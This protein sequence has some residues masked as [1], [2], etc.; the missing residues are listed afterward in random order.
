MELKYK[1]NRYKFDINHDLLDLEHA[2]KADS[3]I[4][5]VPYCHNREEY[6][7]PEN[8]GLRDFLHPYICDLILADT[9]GADID[10]SVPT[11]WLIMNYNCGLIKLALTH[12]YTFSGEYVEDDAMCNDELKSVVRADEKKAVLD[13]VKFLW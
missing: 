3:S 13:R 7:L 5:Y 8:A 6:Y 9:R 10:Y 4:I 11:L 1:N 12:N 2:I